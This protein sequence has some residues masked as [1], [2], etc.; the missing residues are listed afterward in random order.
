LVRGYTSNGA[1]QLRIENLVGSIENGKLADLLVFDENLF[2]ADHYEIWQIE[3]S[4]VVIE[5]E[6][7]RGALPE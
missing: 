5:G 2:E 6:L 1:Y 4:I 7:I 3:P